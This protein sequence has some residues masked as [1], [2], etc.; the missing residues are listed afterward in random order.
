MRNF[1]ILYSTH[2]DPH[3]PN[4]A[5]QVDFGYGINGAIGQAK[6]YSEGHPE[7]PFWKII[8]AVET[9]DSK[10]NFIIGREILRDYGTILSD[11][12]E[13]SLYG[14]KGFYIPNA[15]D[16]NRPAEASKIDSG[17]FDSSNSK[18]TEQGT[19]SH[20]DCDLTPQN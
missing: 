15:Q 2:E 16:L 9:R 4:A 7:F 17:S 20:Q 19:N 13:V 11:P 10:G 3:H 6:K 5:I 12:S 1:G 18:H 8:V 14:Y